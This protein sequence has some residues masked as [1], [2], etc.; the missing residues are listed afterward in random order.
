MEVMIPGRAANALSANLP[1]NCDKAFNLFLSTPKLHHLF[2]R[3]LGLY[4]KP[5]ACI[6]WYGPCTQLVNSKYRQVMASK[7]KKIF[8]K[9]YSGR[10][11]ESEERH[12]IKIVGFSFCMLFNCL[13]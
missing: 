7:E 10:N 12:G 5:W 8:L 9:N 2:Y 6:S 1:D 13:Y 3:K 4:E 11:K